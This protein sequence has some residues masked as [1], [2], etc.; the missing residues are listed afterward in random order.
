MQRRSGVLDDPGRLLDGDVGQGPV[1]T[2]DDVPDGR[3]EGLVVAGPELWAEDDM[4]E[5]CAVGDLFSKMRQ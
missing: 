4:T 3:E 2:F 5:L 1:A